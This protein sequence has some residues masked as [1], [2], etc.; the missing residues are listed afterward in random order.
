ML[1]VLLVFVCLLRSTLPPHFLLCVSKVILEYLLLMPQVFNLCQKIFNALMVCIIDFL[2]ITVFTKAVDILETVARTP[3]M[4]ISELLNCRIFPR[5]VTPVAPVL[6]LFGVFI[7]VLHDFLIGHF[8]ITLF[9]SFGSLRRSANV[10]CPRSR[11]FSH[12]FFVFLAA[13]SFCRGRYELLKTGRALVLLLL[14]HVEAAVIAE[15]GVAL[16]AQQGHVRDG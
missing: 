16:R 5:V 9:H 2:H 13:F 8:P 3:P 12:I 4:Q 15:N 1:F 7:D 11:D 10:P 14:F 6:V